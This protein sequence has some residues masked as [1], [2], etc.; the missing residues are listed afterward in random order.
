M[1]VVDTFRHTLSIPPEKKARLAACLEEF[2]SI[3]SASAHDIASLRGRLQHYS[4]C[5]PYVLRLPFAALFSS[6]LGTEA[7]PDYNRLI[8][9][10]PVINDTAAFL[11]GV[12]EDYAFR[13]RLLWP[14]IASTLHA[15]FLAGETGSA[16]IA[17][18]T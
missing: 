15:A 17:V 5:V 9:I 2:L 6:L 14:L 18:V 4:C 1:I 10:P 13:G 11:W 8:E 12:L 3:R 16:H 7:E